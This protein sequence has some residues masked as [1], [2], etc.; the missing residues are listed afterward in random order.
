MKIVYTCKQ[1]I[2]LAVLLCYAARYG[3]AGASA[4]RAGAPENRQMLKS[5]AAECRLL[6]GLSK[7]R[8]VSVG[9]CRGWGLGEGRGPLHT[10]KLSH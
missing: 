3:G 6:S 7:R 1:L 5:K 2:L 8:R 9:I 10:L 4:C